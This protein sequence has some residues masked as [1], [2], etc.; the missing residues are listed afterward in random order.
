MKKN[1]KMELRKRARAVSGLI[2]LLRDDIDQVRVDVTDYDLICLEESLRDTR[3]TL[4]M[5][6][7]NV[8]EME[9]MLYLTKQG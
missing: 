8:A 2:D 7:D 6:I 1:V 9:Y 5:I 3:S 4:Q